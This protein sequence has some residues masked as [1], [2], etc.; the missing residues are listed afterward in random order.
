MSGVRCQVSF[1]ACH[2]LL[3]G[4]DQGSAT[5][6]IPIFVP[7][8]SVLPES[9]G[10]TDMS[11]T[12][13]RQRLPERAFEWCKLGKAVCA[14]KAAGRAES[15]SKA[16][17]WAFIT[18]SFRERRLFR[19]PF[20][21]CFASPTARSGSADCVKFAQNSIRQSLESFQIACRTDNHLKDLQAYKLRAVV[22]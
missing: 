8:R 20:L 10:E 3:S 13:V 11:C 12:S 2:A 18:F 7:T 15:I 1:R 17:N 14:S 19:S 4:E 9:G 16:N 21:H 6:E 5:A 22:H